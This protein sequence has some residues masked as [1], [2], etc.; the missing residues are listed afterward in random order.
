MHKA[1]YIFLC[2]LV[3]LA[4]CAAMGGKQVSQKNVINACN[5]YAHALATLAAF[6]AKGELTKGEVSQVNK[7][8]KQ[9]H[10]ICT[11]STIP[12]PATALM[13]VNGATSQ[14]QNLQ[15]PPK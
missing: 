2:L 13:T 15:V 3:A 10:P 9:V 5:G 4:G 14:L 6:R 7:I 1:K 12:D 11:A 8:I